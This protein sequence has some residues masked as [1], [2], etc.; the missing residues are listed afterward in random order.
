MLRVSKAE[1]IARVA[2]WSLILLAPM[3]LLFCDIK[4]KKIML[5]RHAVV[6]F[7]RKPFKA[8]FKR[9]IPHNSKL[10]EF[11]MNSKLQFWVTQTDKVR[12]VGQ[13]SN[14]IRQTE[15]RAAWFQMKPFITDYFSSFHKLKRS[16]FVPW[17]TFTRSI[18]LKQTDLYNILV[19]P[20]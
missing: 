19:D 8:Y 5:L 7:R 2:H 14:I 20:S 4:D 17:S 16:T 1:E 18:R 12:P 10:H 11:H 3:P 13:M 6:Q 15:F 9:W